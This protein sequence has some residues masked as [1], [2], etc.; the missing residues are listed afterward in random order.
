MTLSK[1]IQIFLRVLLA[2]VILDT[3]SG[4]GILQ[5]AA[6]MRMIAVYSRSAPLTEALKETFDGQH[7]CGLCESIQK[8]KQTEKKPE[9]IQL[10]IKREF[11][12]QANGTMILTPSTDS[13]LRVVSVVNLSTISERPPV[14]P[15]R[16]LLG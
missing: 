16:S 10:D 12:C 4:H 7:P 1:T 6:W 11:F 3:T 15:P 5:M 2:V 9:A 13:W 8:A 14:P